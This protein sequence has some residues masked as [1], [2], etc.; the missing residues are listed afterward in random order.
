MATEKDEPIE[1]GGMVLPTALAAALRYLITI[2]GTFAIGRGWVKAEELPGL[3]TMAVTLATVGYGLWK[4]YSNRSKL[5]VTAEAAPN[6][7]AVVTK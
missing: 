4:T 6:D 3:A 1:V 5:V 7:V 2:I